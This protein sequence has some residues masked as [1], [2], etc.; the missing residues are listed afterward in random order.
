MGMG[1]GIGVG[2]G[3][4]MAPL[5]SVLLM[6][7]GFRFAGGVGGVGS[8]GGVGGV[9]GTRAPASSAPADACHFEDC[10]GFCSGRYGRTHVHTP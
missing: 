9:G 5:P 10:A 4:G 6:I 2:V 8:V 7:I 1:M 3:M